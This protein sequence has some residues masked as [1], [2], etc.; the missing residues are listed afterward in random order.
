MR[1][2]AGIALAVAACA[3]MGSQDFP[4]DKPTY[5]E[6][7]TVGVPN[8]AAIVKRIWTP[9]LDEGWVPQG[10]TVSGPFV[11]VAQY[12]PTPDL[13]SG[14]GP[15]R[16]VR[17]DRETG[18]AAGSFAMPEGVCTHAGGLADLGGGRLLLAD[19]R[20][21]FR[22]DMERAFASGQAQG[23]MKSLRLAGDL[24][25]SYAGFDG[26]D[27]WIGT[28]TKDAAKSHMYR[29]SWKLFDERDG[30]VIDHT[31][32]L[33]KRVVPLESQGL[34]FDAQGRAWTSSSSG[35]FGRLHRLTASGSVEAKW[36]MVPGL[37]DLGFDADG[38]LWAVSESGTR[39]Y[40]HWPTKFPFVFAIDVE[41]L[42]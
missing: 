2:V 13:K 23:A 15:C 22:I 30:Q 19:T 35:S 5:V 8:E 26:L 12:K 32:A 40:L 7:A 42:K 6:A 31:V 18:R 14:T 38:R 3:S 41:K 33:E 29:L 9:G 28:W 27:P 36:E 11:L 34:A 10:L 25:G 24:R 16:V 39:K 1:I 20:A 37:E 21:I 17:L 4:G